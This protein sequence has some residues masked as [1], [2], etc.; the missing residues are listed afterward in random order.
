MIE[1]DFSHSVEPGLIGKHRSVFLSGR[2][3]ELP[4]STLCSRPTLSMLT[5]SYTL[6]RMPLPNYFGNSRSHCVID[7]DSTPILLEYGANVNVKNSEGKS[8]L[9]LTSGRKGKQ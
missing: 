6:E 3:P 7:Q 9:Q 1:G 5:S 4:I 8:Q 2:L